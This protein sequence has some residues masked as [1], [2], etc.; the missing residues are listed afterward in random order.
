MPL[1]CNYNTASLHLSAS[2]IVHTAENVIRYNNPV[3]PQ[4]WSLPPQALPEREKIPSVALFKGLT[5]RTSSASIATGTGTGSLPA[6][7]P[8]VAECA[9]HLELLQTFYYLRRNVSD[10]T[11]LD[12]RW[13]IDTR[14][15]RAETSHRDSTLA[16]KRRDKWPFFMK[17]AAVRFLNWL[18]RTDEYLST[19]PEELWSIDAPPLGMNLLH[20]LCSAKKVAIVG[21]VRD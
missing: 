5:D 13:D 10:S 18:K 9:V 21:S 16:I 3:P 7:L 19:T 12:V 1:Q 20:G 11:E 2:S 8:S 4:A 15:A 6:H 17:L 14:H